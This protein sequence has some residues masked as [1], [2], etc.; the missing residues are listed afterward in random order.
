MDNNYPTTNSSSHNVNPVQPSNAIRGEVLPPIDEKQINQYFKEQELILSKYWKTEEQW[1]SVHQNEERKMVQFFQEKQK[2]L[3]LQ[4]NILNYINSSGMCLWKN[5]TKNQI[6]FRANAQ[7]EPIFGSQEKISIHLSERFGRKIKIVF[8]YDKIDANSILDNT[9][10]IFTCGMLAVENDIYDPMYFSKN[11]EILNFNPDRAH[12]FPFYG[13]NQFRNLFIPT[14]YLLQKFYKYD[15][16]TARN[17]IIYNFIFQMVGEDK[18][19]FDYIINW[20]AYFYQMMQK[21]STLLIFIGDKKVINEIFID[22]ILKPIFGADNFQTINKIFLEKPNN[23]EFHNKLFYHIDES[24]STDEQGLVEN[25]KKYIK[26]MLLQRPQEQIYGQALITSNNPYPFVKDFYSKCVLV[27]ISYLEQILEKLS[28]QDSFELSKQIQIDLENFSN[29]LANYHVDPYLTCEPIDTQKKA[30]LQKTEKAKFL[31]FIAALEKKDLAFFEK[32]KYENAEVYEDLEQFFSEDLI[33]QSDLYI[34][35]N[36]LF[37]EYTFTD[38][39]TLIPKL[40]ELSPIFNQEAKNRIK[41]AKTYKLSNYEE[42]LI[43]ENKNS[44]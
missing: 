7:S 23:E 39:R 8:D 10:Y 5:L 33:K 9:V 17:S 25:L 36:I 3:Q 18:C 2:I 4:Q 12:S 11:N 28:L 22:E 19:I 30:S 44:L 34:Y 15:L 13:N 40:K 6:F 41:N 21:P 26:R 38:N 1:R 29:V 42:F 35:I 43:P 16:S 27:E 20:V 31:E 24:F 14:S 37:K 32:V